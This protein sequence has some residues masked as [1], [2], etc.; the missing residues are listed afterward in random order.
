ML[1]QLD[2][3]APPA[4]AFD[5]S[6]GTLVRRELA[7]GAWVDHARD[8]VSNHAALF[9]QLERE[10]TWRTDRRRMYDKM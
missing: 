1:R 5:A 7:D 6:F 2:L 4:L 3:F 9:D 8:W 10:L